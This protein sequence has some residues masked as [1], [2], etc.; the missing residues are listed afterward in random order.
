MASRQEIQMPK[1][2]HVGMGLMG[3]HAPSSVGKHDGSSFRTASNE[4]LHMGPG[5]ILF[6]APITGLGA[7]IACN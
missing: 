2:L 6:H 4:K 1:L 7:I 3:K 5:S